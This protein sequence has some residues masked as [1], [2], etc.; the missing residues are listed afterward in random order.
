MTM[1]NKHREQLASTKVRVEG[2]TICE[3]CGTDKGFTIQNDGNYSQKTIEG[4]I[5]RQKREVSHIGHETHLDKLIESHR[6]I[7]NQP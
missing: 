5:E 6:I 3:V 2:R 7:L 4:W 1:S